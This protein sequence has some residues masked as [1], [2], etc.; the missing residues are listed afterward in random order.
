MKVG[1]D[2]SF[3]DAVVAYVAQQWES[4]TTQLGRTVMQKVCYF[5]KAK[6]VPLDYTFE[7]YHYG[8]YSQELYFRLDELV[9]DGIIK[10]M[11][12]TP[13]KS[14]YVPD[15]KD[16]EILEMHYESLMP[17]RDDIN[18]IIKLLT[19][20]GPADLEL[21][22]TIHYFQ[23]SYGKFYKNPP[24]KDFVVAKVIETKKD[25]FAPD[26]ISRAYDALQS[27]GLFEDPSVFKRE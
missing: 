7:M 1:F 10:D 18:Q 12:S 14:V 21:L 23:T 27:A 11:S 3:E 24:S 13:K 15:E 2:Y 22:A 8:P 17:Y 19:N 26:L 9:A 20:F 4:T 6:G 25:K 16:N 5:L